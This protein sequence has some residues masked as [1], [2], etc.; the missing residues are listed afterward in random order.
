MKD[1]V[2]AMFK[3]ILPL[4]LAVLMLCGC[5]SKEAK[6]PG[7]TEA[8]NA[9]VVESGIF[10]KTEGTPIEETVTKIYGKEAIKAIGDFEGTTEE[11]LE[12][13]PA[14]CT[15]ETESGYRAMYLGSGEVAMVVIDDLLTERYAYTMINSMTKADF[16]TL[17]VGDPI[18]TVQSLDKNGNYAF[19]TALWDRAPVLSWHATTDGYMVFIRYD[20][21]CNIV[22]VTFELI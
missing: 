14:E 12:A 6:K 11:F 10:D 1:G 22:S 13:Y 7:E 4:L 3:R 2:K 8:V 15:R 18:A 16:E 9:S 17:K 19:G 5:S 20:D 21:D